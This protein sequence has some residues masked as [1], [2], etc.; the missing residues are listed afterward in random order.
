MD[1]YQSWL[2]LESFKFEFRLGDI[3]NFFGHRNVFLFPT[4]ENELGR[5]LGQGKIVQISCNRNWG[6]EINA[7]Q[8]IVLRYF[9]FGGNLLTAYVVCS[10]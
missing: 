3:L 8:Y 9:Y 7:T 2:V 6:L 10:L 1:S 4:I 5:L